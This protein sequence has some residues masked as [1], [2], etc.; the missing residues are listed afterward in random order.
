M[1][2]MITKE[3]TC[4]NPKMSRACFDKKG[5]GL[6]LRPYQLIPDHVD[7]IGEQTTALT[8]HLN[9]MGANPSDPFRHCP[10]PEY[11][12]FLGPNKGGNRSTARRNSKRP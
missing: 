10:I 2:S 11:Q 12:G 7:E 8:C 1:R 5:A 3:M 9:C 4:I 6:F